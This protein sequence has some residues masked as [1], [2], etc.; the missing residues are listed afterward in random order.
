[1]SY[2]YDAEA[3]TGHWV[4]WPG[5]F[6]WYYVAQYMGLAIS[7]RRMWRCFNPSARQLMVLLPEE[8]EATPT[9]PRYTNPAELEI[10]P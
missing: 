4:R 8:L 7:G 9:S 1:M 3:L 2:R 10:W 5:S 6:G